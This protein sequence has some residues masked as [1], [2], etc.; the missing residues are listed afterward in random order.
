MKLKN[1][2]PFVILWTILLLKGCNARQMEKR[3]VMDNLNEGLKFAG[4]M[5]G[6]NTAADVA[7]L[8][9]K[10][11]ST[12][13]NKGKPD[14]V[15]LLQKGLQAIPSS[16]SAT[17]SEEQIRQTEKRHTHESMESNRNYNRDNDRLNGGESS[18]KS[19][20]SGQNDNF[21]LNTAKFVTSMLRM[22]G[23]DAT[24]LGALAINVLI[25]LASTIGTTLLGGGG[26][27]GK[28]TKPQR[29]KNVYS[30]D[31]YNAETGP[32]EVYGPNDH[33]PRE[34][35]EGTPFDWFLQNPSKQMKSLLDQAID[36]NLSD[37]II[38]MIENHE[39]TGN[40]RSCLKMLIC[41]SSPFIWGMQKSVKNRIR[42]DDK[43]NIESIKSEETQRPYDVE[44]LYT[45][46]P[47]LDE[48][49]DHAV[50]CDQLY[51]NVCNT[52][53]LHQRNQN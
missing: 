28:P 20:S 29:T 38:K 30:S 27:G 3:G 12:T 42:G 50:K 19:S 33:Q 25:M 52:K 1:R 5:F 10:A 22:V 41:K 48:F 31:D 2:I 49:R 34:L 24:K 51:S 23:F 11:F 8:V 36:T 13:S 40:E 9:A 32:E 43:E 47:S 6:V 18:E 14:L 53:K 15:S 7:N 17:S 46:M 21:G 45:H 26:G 39:T 44:S 37:K 35:M 4:Q 16:T